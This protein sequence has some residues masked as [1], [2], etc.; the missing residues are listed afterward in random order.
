MTVL[1][2]VAASALG[3]PAGCSVGAPH[4]AFDDALA[5]GEVAAGALD[6]EALAMAISEAN[7]TFPCLDEP[8]STPDVARWYRLRGI[9][10][11]VASDAPSV[12]RWFV[13]S[14]SLEPSYP[15]DPA[16]GSALGDAWAAAGVSSDPWTRPLPPP[17]AGW[18][19]VDGRRSESAP[20][21][22]PFVLQRFDGDG[23][24][25]ANALLLPDDP[26]PAWPRRKVAPPTGEV[27]GHRSRTF[28]A[29]GLATGVAAGAS[30]GAATALRHAY[31]AS[32]KPADGLRGTLAANRVF[33]W[34]S[35][36]FGAAAA[37]LGVGAVAVGEW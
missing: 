21:K 34:G 24:V 14:R 7:T 36:G 10:R 23:A 37:G 25:V 12:T 29:I 3:A 13:A 30:A 35:V 33:G 22:R 16:L 9:E 2:L 11:F 28:L 32:D 5:A 19:Q 4:Q 26:L 1:A 27:T 6:V 20:A 31:V 8:L 18:L 15:L 17:A